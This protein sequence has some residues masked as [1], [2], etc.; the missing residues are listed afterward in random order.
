M[1]EFLHY[2]P[3]CGHELLA[4]QLLCPKC[5][6][7]C[8]LF[9]PDDLKK[10]KA[11]LSSKTTKSIDASALA[12][13]DAKF[14]DANTQWRKYWAG[15]E[16]QTG[17]GFAAEDANAFWDKIHF[18]KVTLDGRNNALDGPDRIVDG[19]QI[20]TKYCKNAISSVNAAFKDGHYRYLDTSGQPMTLEVPRDQYEEA[21]KL[22]EQKIRDGELGPTIT[23]PSQASNLVKR[24]K[25]TYK[26]AQNIARAGNF[27]SLRFD[28]ETGAVFAL[29]AFTISFIIDIGLIAI[30]NR[31]TGI[32][33][34]DLVYAALVSSLKSGGIVFATHI[35][36]QQLLK[37]QFV[38]NKV[39]AVAEKKARSV[40]NEIWSSKHGKKA[41][42]KV[43]K[44]SI[45]DSRETIAKRI[46][47][48]AGLTVVL[49][50]VTET[51]III[52]YA[53]GRISGRQASKDSIVNTMSI[54]GGLI[55]VPF[56]GWVA[57]PIGIAGSV[58]GRKIGVWVSDLL[59]EGDSEKMQKLVTLAEIRLAEDYLL[60]SR[61]DMQYVQDSI[62]YY[63]VID[64]GFLESMYKAGDK[65]KDDIA[66]YHLAYSRLAYYFEKALRRREH[67][68]MASILQHYENV[69]EIVNKYDG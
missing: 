30:S 32:A 3:N 10:K 64:I 23:D 21:V 36:T 20:Q 60:Y 54:L 26:Q 56:G 38:R 46:G 44:T 17:H 59:G 31:N 69:V 35:G 9:S 58:F 4:K 16:G 55:S 13:L 14:I 66:S 27:D 67:V 18:K 25:Y 41:L 34:E 61:E 53:S 24:G 33:I 62:M 15:S 51:P 65:G 29:G 8:E 22:M 6:T 11:C 43:A 40:L 47:T 48:G 39:V 12:P 42:A 45:K 37:T 68:E 5:D 52:K 28:A 19:V 49:L 2:C 63:N 57:F 7:C 1:T 50:T